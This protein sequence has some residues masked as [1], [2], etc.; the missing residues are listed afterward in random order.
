MRTDYTVSKTRF[1]TLGYMLVVPGVWRFV[2]ISERMPVS[3]SDCRTVGPQY[4][5]KAELLADMQD[6]AE[7]AGWHDPIA[8]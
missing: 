2:D 1:A 7:R 3:W 6:Y 5:T 8:A 4:A